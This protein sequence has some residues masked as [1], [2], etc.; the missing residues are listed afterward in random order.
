MDLRNYNQRN[1][2]MNKNTLVAFFLVGLMVC[3]IGAIC[4]SQGTKPANDDPLF[5]G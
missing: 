2:L 4:A 1:S 5:I 3:T